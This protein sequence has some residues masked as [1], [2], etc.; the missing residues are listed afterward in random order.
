MRVPLRYWYDMPSC[1]H[2]RCARCCFIS[3]SSSS[4]SSLVA[5]PRMHTVQTGCSDVQGPTWRRAILP[6]STRLH[7]WSSWSTSAAFCWLQPCCCATSQ[8]VYSRQSPLP[9]SW[10]AC[11][12]TL[13]WLIRCWLF[14][15]NWNI[16]CSSSPTQMLY[17]NCCPTVLLWHS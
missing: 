1:L 7:H 11:L 6:W 16:I 13:C 9:N 15:A 10:T 14:G 12:M 8:T 4:S 2:D 5:R 3:S 17:C